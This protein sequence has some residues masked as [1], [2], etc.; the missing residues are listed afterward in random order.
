MSLM[1][2]GTNILGYCNSE[3]DKAV[4]KVVEKGNLTTLNCP[5]EVFLAERLIELHPWSDMVRFARTGG[6]ANAIA[7]RIA[8]AATGKDK[9]AICG[10]HGWHDW[11][12]A[13][14]LG[15]GQNLDGHLLPGLEPKGV[16]TSLRG[17][18][19]TFSYNK[20]DELEK[21]IADQDIGPGGIGVMEID[22]SDP[23]HVGCEMIDL[24]D[25]AGGHQAVIQPSKV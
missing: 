18:T 6:E 11:Y 20:I 21:L 10:Y 8:R 4:K 1:G 19:L 3:V 13:A 9:V 25:L 2:V 17:T 12:L 7:I 24:I 14:N 15:N 23:P 5:E 16:P 22:V